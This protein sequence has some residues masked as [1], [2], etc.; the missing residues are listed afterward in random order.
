M[1]V[2]RLLL[3]T[4]SVVFCVGSVLMSNILQPLTGCFISDMC[5][6]QCNKTL[7]ELH[8]TVSGEIKHAVYQNC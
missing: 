5:K 2:T 4:L 7:T 8:L 6:K 3:F 1:F